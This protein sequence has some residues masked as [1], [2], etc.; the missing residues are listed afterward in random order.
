MATYGLTPQGFIQKR[1][2]EI[3]Q[4]KRTKTIQLF[5]DMVEPG[6]IVDVGESSLLGRLIAID[7]ET[8]SIIWETMQDVY[9]A[10]DPNS[11]TGASLDNVVAYGAITRQKASPS[12]ASMLMY[13]NSGVVIP[14]GSSMRSVTTNTEYQTTAQITLSP[15]RASGVGIVISTVSNNTIYKVTYQNGSFSVTVTY[16]SS[17][18]ASKSEILYGIKSVIDSA[19]PA[20]VADIVGEI[21]T[22]YKSEIFEFSDFSVTSNMQIIKCANVVQAVASETGP[23]LNEANTITN[24]LT[25]ILGWD[26]ATNPLAA[27]LGSNTETDEEL[28]LR[29][30]NSKAVRANNLI[31][32][33]YSSLYEIPEVSSVQVYENYTDSI[34]EKGVLP[35]SFKTVVLGGDSQLIASAIWKNKPVGIGT[36]GTTM[37]TVLDSYSTPHE[38]AFVRP[39][40][41]PVYINLQLTTFPDFPSDGV[42]QI[43]S[44]LVSYFQDNFGVGKE[45]IYSRLYTP[46]NS[47]R[48]HQIVSL[49]I[50][51]DPNVLGTGNIQ[52]PFDGISSLST[53]NI[54]VYT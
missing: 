2:P 15:V 41:V 38:I 10:L 39:S 24:I 53:A 33:L 44:E 16:T 20:L 45:I 51:I 28:R 7:A 21:L 42:E 34:D 25:P 30:R 32:S 6:D 50:G 47:V 3:L 5:Q 14:Q 4:D 54:N 37:V 29:F 36:V 35:H 12:V 13:G 1:L 52:V 48:G 8:D 31:E 43:K 9:S 27:S 18:N 46:I 23:V 49:N 11:A 19:H 22:L 40:P 26:S 17:A